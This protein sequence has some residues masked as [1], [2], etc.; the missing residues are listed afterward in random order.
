MKQ[1]LFSI[2]L[3]MALV[4]AG[5]PVPQRHLEPEDSGQVGR[6]PHTMRLPVFSDYRRPGLGPA[7]MATDGGI[8]HFG[9]RR[10]DRVLTGNDASYIAQDSN[11]AWLGKIAYNLTAICNKWKSPGGDPWAGMRHAVGRI[12]LNSD[13]WPRGE[14]PWYAP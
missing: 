3:A 11:P 6:A 4:A 10:K 13:A 7:M 8:R 12:N 5:P 14:K 2:G 9:S 1:H